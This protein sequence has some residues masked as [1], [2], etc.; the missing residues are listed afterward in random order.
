M[1]Y[2]L[3]PQHPLI[4]YPYLLRHDTVQPGEYVPI[5][6]RQVVHYYT[7]THQQQCVVKQKTRL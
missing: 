6:D 7:H 5:F 1:T 3:K 2:T 4:K